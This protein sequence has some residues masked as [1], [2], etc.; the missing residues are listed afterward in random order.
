M[1]SKR[2][3]NPIDVHAGGRIRLRRTLLGMAYR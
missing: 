2:F 1:A 3:P